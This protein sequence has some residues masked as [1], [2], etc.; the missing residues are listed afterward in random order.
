[1]GIFTNKPR[2][3][4][5]LSRKQVRKEKR[6][7]KSLR[8]SDFFAKKRKPGQFVINPERAT[9]DSVD[10]VGDTFVDQ[11]NLTALKKTNKQQ[12]TKVSKVIS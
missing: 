8:K 11:S 7:E 2:K 10:P 6:R 5:Q 1:M 12:K 3:T 4:S 9:T